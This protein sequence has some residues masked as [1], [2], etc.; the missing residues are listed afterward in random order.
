MGYSSNITPP[1]RNFVASATIL[2]GR[3]WGV[4]RL[5]QIR[6]AMTQA[7]RHLSHTAPILASLAL[8][9]FEELTAACL[10]WS[11]DL[12]LG[13]DVWH[14]CSAGPPLPRKGIPAQLEQVPLHQAIPCFVG[15]WLEFGK[16]LHVRFMWPAPTT[17]ELLGLGGQRFGSMWATH[18]A[19]LGLQHARGRRRPRARSWCAR[20]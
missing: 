8:V 16:A 17:G 15:V 1:K 19:R 11:G 10:Q 9:I 18:T 7:Y 5:I 4:A 14:R 13:Q 3:Y 6:H 2:R 20:R 12:P